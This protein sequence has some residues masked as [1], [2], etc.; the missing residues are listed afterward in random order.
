MTHCS[1]TV[2]LEKSMEVCVIGILAVRNI[3]KKVKR[4]RDV[5]DTKRSCT[6]DLGL[7]EGP[8]LLGFKVYLGTT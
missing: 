4:A 8:I 6:V 3:N 5:K 7:A 1:V 2:Y